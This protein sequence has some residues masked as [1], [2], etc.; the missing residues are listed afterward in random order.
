MHQAIRVQQNVDGDDLVERPLVVSIRPSFC[1]EIPNRS[2][3]R[4]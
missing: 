1:I 4:C 2:A 3:T